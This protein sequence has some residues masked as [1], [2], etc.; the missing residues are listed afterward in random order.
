MR[1]FEPF[2]EFNPCKDRPAPDHAENVIRVAPEEYRKLVLD[3]VFARNFAELAA[4]EIRHIA[5]RGYGSTDVSTAMRVMLRLYDPELYKKAANSEPGNVG[6]IF[7]PSDILDRFSSAEP[8]NGKIWRPDK[9]LSE[10]MNDFMNEHG[11]EVE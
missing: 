11:T 1:S 5:E 8:S 3:S 7:T 6:T 9:P 4:E 2:P 10:C